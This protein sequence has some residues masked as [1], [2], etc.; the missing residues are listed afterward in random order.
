[1]ILGS[2]TPESRKKGRA[3]RAD[4]ISTQPAAENVAIPGERQ[5]L[6]EGDQSGRLV[7]TDI[8]QLVEFGDGENLVDVGL[9]VA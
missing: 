3:V 5:L 1:M 9:N 2:A 8:E 4:S 6:L 7:V